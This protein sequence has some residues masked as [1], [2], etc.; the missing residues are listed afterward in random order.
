MLF[1]KPFDVVTIGGIPLALTIRLAL[2]HFGDQK[3]ILRIGQFRPS[4]TVHQFV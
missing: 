1:V 3:T 2:E 4:A